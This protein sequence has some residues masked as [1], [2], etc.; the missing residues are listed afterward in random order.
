[1]NVTINQ[2][3]PV[4]TAD[5]TLEL[6]SMLCTVS[7]GKYPETVNSSI[8]LG[9]DEGIS[10]TSTKPEVEKAAIAKFKANVDAML[11][12]QPQADQQPA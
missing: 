11:A 5:G 12:P 3:T 4:F 8:E 9:K 7:G 1:M 6:Q 2:I 10:L